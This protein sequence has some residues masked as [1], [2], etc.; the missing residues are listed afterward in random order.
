MAASKKSKLDDNVQQTSIEED[1]SVPEEIEE[2][3]LN[4]HYSLANLE[5]LLKPVLSTNRPNDEEVL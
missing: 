2:Q 3:C 4:C 1:D 5:T